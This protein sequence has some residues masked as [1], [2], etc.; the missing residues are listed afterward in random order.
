MRKLDILAKNLV[1]VFSFRLRVF[2]QTPCF[3][4][5]S[6]FCTRPRVF[7]QTPCFL[8]DPAFSTRPRFFHTPGPRTGQPGTPALRFPPS[9]LSKRNKYK[10]LGKLRYAK[11]RYYYCFFGCEGLGWQRCFTRQTHW[12]RCCSLVPELSFSSH[13]T[14]SA[15]VA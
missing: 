10:I 5:V 11:A 14:A 13:F 8:P 7:H 6:A 2:H 9:R 15:Q 12:L 4:P 3:P 1:P